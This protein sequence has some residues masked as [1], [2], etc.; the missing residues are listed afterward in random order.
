M[1]AIL[2]GL[3]QS[4]K[5]IQVFAYVLKVHAQPSEQS[6][7]FFRRFKETP[8]LLHAY[9]LQGVNDAEDSVAVAIW[10]SREAAERYLSQ[11][12]LRREVDQGMPG[13][14]RTLYDVL[15]SK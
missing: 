12:A 14:T 10:E 7:E 8:G 15:D 6:N 2:G 5:E 9:S 3:H 1:M 13:I 4:H 11:S